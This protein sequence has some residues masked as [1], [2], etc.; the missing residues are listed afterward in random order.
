MPAEPLL[1]AGRC[2]GGAPLTRLV[3][4]QHQSEGQQERGQQDGQLAP[5]AAAQHGQTQPPDSAGVGEGGRRRHQGT[6]RSQGTG[7]SAHNGQQ[8]PVQSTATERQSSAVCGERR[9]LIPL[10][11]H[12]LMDWASIAGQFSRR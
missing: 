4:Q 2:F 8:A 7:Q 9:R 1:G 10:R 6:A 5:G 3:D 11:A 12:S